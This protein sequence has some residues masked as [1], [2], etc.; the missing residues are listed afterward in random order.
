MKDNRILEISEDIFSRS[1]KRILLIKW[2][3]LSGRKKDISGG[4]EFRALQLI[5]DNKFLL[6]K[7]AKIYGQKYI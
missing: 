6:S 1:Q 2:D 7:C 3:L 4:P 5:A